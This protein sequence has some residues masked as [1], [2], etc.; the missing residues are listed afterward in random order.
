MTAALPPS[1]VVF[2]DKQSVIVMLSWQ[3]CLRSSHP[4]I[5]SFF[6][7]VEQTILIH[8]VWAGRARWGS[9]ARCLGWGLSA[10]GA[11]RFKCNGELNIRPDECGS[12]R[13]QLGTRI[14]SGCESNAYML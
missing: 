8:L 3:L 7:K 12:L 11:A 13:Q 14:T 5:S 6:D 2:V 1:C 10:S 9:F 4:F